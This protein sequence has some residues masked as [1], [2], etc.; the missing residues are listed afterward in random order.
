MRHAPQTGLGGV[1][2]P[3][4]D[5]FSRERYITSRK[6]K[7]STVKKKKMLRRLPDLQKVLDSSV[8]SQKT[9]HLRSLPVLGRLESLDRVDYDNRG[10]PTVRPTWPI[11]S[12]PLRRQTSEPTE[13]SS[14]W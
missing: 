10:V 8:F 2:L 14:K 4:L 6:N 9:T 13:A 12:W 11:E 5:P 3:S 7:H 1:T